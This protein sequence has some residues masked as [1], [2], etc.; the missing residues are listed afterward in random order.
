MSK[1]ALATLG[2]ILSLGA[3]AQDLSTAGFTKRFTL[4]KNAEGKVTAIKVKSA[5]K[6]QF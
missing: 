3:F 2:L 6:R 5:V 4:V 1:F